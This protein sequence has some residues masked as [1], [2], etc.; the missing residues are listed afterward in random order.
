MTPEYEKEKS[1]ALVREAHEITR[2]LKVEIDGLTRQMARVLDGGEDERVGANG[3]QEIAAGTA[4]V[5]GA[6]VAKSGW[7]FWR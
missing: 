4:I 1:A 3:R 5:K 2:H 6:K 7:L